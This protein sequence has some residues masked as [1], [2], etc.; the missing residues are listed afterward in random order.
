M[1]F[2]TIIL[3]FLACV[4]FAE[5]GSMVTVGKAANTAMLDTTTAEA[6]TPSLREHFYRHSVYQLSPHRSGHH[7]LIQQ[8][9]DI[10][11]GCFEGYSPAK[12]TVSAKPLNAKSGRVGARRLWSFTTEGVSGEVETGDFW[13]LYRID[14]PG[15]CGSARTSKY[16]SLETGKLVGSTTKRMLEMSFV[17]KY[18]S[19]GVVER[20]FISVEDNIA[21][22]PQAS[23]KAIAT[24]FYA[25]AYALEETVSVSGNG[26]LGSEDWWVSESY[27]MG[28]DSEVQG[29]AL[30]GSEEAKIRVVLKCRCDA[31]PLDIDI[32]VSAAGLNIS[33]SV[34]KGPKGISLAKSPTSTTKL[35]MNGAASR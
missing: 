21:S 4:S 28:Q 8:E 33:T 12:V 34:V 26:K 24:I 23:T 13:G 17:D 35:P 30:S 6:C 5:A 32:P 9:F 1:R 16:F 11:Q 18:D 29:L 25:D 10:G 19:R 20:R 15:C 2:A 27:F 22:S 3:S 31:E 7:A 14:M